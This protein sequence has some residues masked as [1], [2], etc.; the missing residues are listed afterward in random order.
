VAGERLSFYAFEGLKS[1]GNAVLHITSTRFDEPLCLAL[2]ARCDCVLTLHGERGRDSSTE[3]QVGGLDEQACERIEQACARRQF[4]VRRAVGQYAG[5][6]P[7]N[8]CNR[9]R[10]RRGVQL[11]L[12][13]ALRASAFESLSALGRTQRTARFHELVQAIVGALAGSAR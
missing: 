4:Q 8:L 13:R 9:G 3:I 7:E 6:E 2:L 12:S 5:R 1:S 10:S 11:E